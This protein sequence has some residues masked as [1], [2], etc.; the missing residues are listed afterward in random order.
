MR[1]CGYERA[2]KVV[3]LFAIVFATAARFSA[4]QAASQES[5]TQQVRDLTAA[6][7]RTQAQL[8]QSQQA[9]NEMRRQ[10]ADLERRIAQ[11]AGTAPA[12]QPIPD[13]S[14]AAAPSSAAD[15]TQQALEEVRE[16]Q[17]VEDSQIAT[18]EQAKVESE[19]KYPVKVTGL[20][21]F[22]GFVNTG[23]VDMAATPTVALP[24]AGS[25]GASI[26]QTILGFD[27]R[28]PH[29]MGAD[30]YADLRVDFDG[31]PS[32]GNGAS[33]YSGYY[34]SA[35]TLMRLRTAHA[36]LRWG[37][38][39]AFFSLDRPLTSPDTP[40]SLTAVAEPALAWSG[41]L[42]TWNPQFGVSA[43]VGSGG[44]GGI[45]LQTAL[46]DVGDAP[47]SA[48]GS[49]SS[50]GPSSA[51][52]S[53][54]PGVEARAAWLS[55]KREDERSHFG[56]GGYFAPHRSALGP[57]FDS[58][59]ATADA[60]VFLPAGLELT[61]SGYRGAALGGL[62]GGGY[63]DIA[64][65]EDPESGQYYLRPLDDTGGWVQMKE[66]FNQRVEVNAALGIDNV[67]A[68]ELRRFTV[69]GGNWYQNLA[70]NR[71]ITGNVIYSPSA[72]LL[73]SLE[74]RRLNSYSVL[75]APAQTN[76]IGLGTGYRF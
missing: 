62:G 16:R 51:E 58:W 27:A 46:V 53:R 72:Y 13:T 73:F 36:G 43:E 10:L 38:A 14:A 6:M 35:T 11:A 12:S 69:S 40:A 9:L 39:D 29:L 8:E 37:H 55:T 17:Q 71:T 23:A 2:W 74:Y 66:K 34:S 42:W 54:W 52:A 65:G 61:G 21:L 33:S 25:T 15:T 31:M 50:A 45:L 3:P 22:T 44:R 70:R 75:A 19:S 24:G 48:R 76:V 49:N 56:L 41:N 32:A 63:K 64:Y 57:D 1:M 7:A 30:S 60:R 4:A 59:A 68:G 18:H 67:F 26:R 47:L 20:L 28:G 5:L